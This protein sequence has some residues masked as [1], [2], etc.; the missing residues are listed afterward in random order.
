MLE[1]PAFLR[2]SPVDI[3]GWIILS[4]GGCVEHDRTF[5]NIS[6]LHPLNASSTLLRHDNKNYLQKLSDLLGGD[7]G[8]ITLS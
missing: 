6:G 8:T 4:C 1:N 3:W 5:N 7:G 2:L